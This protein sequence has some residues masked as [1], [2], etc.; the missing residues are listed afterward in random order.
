VSVEYIPQVGYLVA[1]NESDLPQLQSS[2][3]HA[4]AHAQDT[5]TGLTQDAYSQY[6]DSM[7]GGQYG[8]HGQGEY[9]QHEQYHSQPGQHGEHGQHGEYGQQAQQAQQGHAQRGQP[10]FSFVYQQGQYVQYVL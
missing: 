10:P 8:Q 7:G 6:A 3:T 5:H 9:G 1:V 4:H 2:H